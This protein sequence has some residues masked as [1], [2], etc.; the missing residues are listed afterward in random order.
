MGLILSS[1]FTILDLIIYR[2]RIIKRHIRKERKC[3]VQSYIFRINIK[4]VFL[5]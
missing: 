5:T 3:S 1:H 2:K 4:T